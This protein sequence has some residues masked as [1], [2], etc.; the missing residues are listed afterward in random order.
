MNRKWQRITRNPS[1]LL[2][3]RSS[4]LLLANESSSRCK[5]RCATTK[6]EIFQVV[7]SNSKLPAVVVQWSTSL[8]NNDS[9]SH[10]SN[11]IIGRCHQLTIVNKMDRI[12]IP[13][14]AMALTTP[15][16]CLL[17]LSP[18]LSADDWTRLRTR[19]VSLNLRICQAH[20]RRRSTRSQIKRQSH[21]KWQ[22]N[23]TIITLLLMLWT[24]AVAQ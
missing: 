19:Q 13:P 1:S 2:R 10:S 9:R 23:H 4:F 11:N 14:R 12:K 17:F 6:K 24:W 7:R 8:F 5:L 15:E 3:W 22:Y 16:R 20:T 18:L 21:L